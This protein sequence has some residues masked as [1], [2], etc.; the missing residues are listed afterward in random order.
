MC[1]LRRALLHSLKVDA[2]LSSD[3]YQNPGCGVMNS[4][5]IIFDLI[6]DLY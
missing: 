1:I 2:S 4:E 6:N 3:I 5:A